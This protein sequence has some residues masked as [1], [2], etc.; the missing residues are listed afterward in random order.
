M[1][2]SGLTLAALLVLSVQLVPAQTI[3][4]SPYFS[5]GKG[6]GII[7]PDS[8]YLLNIRFRMQNRAAFRT[9]SASNLSIDQVEARVRRLRLRFDG[10]IYNPK[11]YYLIQLSFSRSDMDFDDTG[12][13]NVIRDAMIIYSVN[14]HF[15]V[16][17][18]QTKLPGNRQRVTSSGDLQLADRSLVN[19]IF[20]IDRDFGVQLYYNN[21]AG[22]LYYVLRAAISSGEGRNITASDRGLSYTG[23]VELLPLGAFTNGGDYF[24]GDILRE[25]KPK[26]SIGLTASQNNNTTRTG[27]QLGKFLYAPRDMNTLM[28]DLLFKFKGWALACEWLERSA[29]NAV[30]TNADGDV[31][32][33]YTGFGQNYQG[34]Y[35]FANHYEIVGRYSRVAPFKQIQLLDDQTQQFTMGLNKYIRGHRVKL[36]GDITFEQNK[37]LQQTN[38][39]SNNW[40]VRFQIE[41]G[42]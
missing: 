23:R 10:Y 31:R 17:L 6:L 27:G 42:I 12:F 37:W 19:S 2:F 13:P 18:G 21:H 30:T 36:Q 38:P 15:S 26:L 35:Y 33:I 28:A 5:F 11:F 7:S 24:E 41:A 14:E 8:L 39:S 4:P 29:N 3:T 9:E 16:G 22:K 20:N 40:Q 25:P 34:S 1:K 32:F